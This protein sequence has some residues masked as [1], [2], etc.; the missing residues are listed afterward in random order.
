MSR[1]RRAQTDE[2][3]SIVFEQGEDDGTLSMQRT[4][5]MTQDILSYEAKGLL[6]TLLSFPDGWKT[7]FN[8][9]V[10]RFCGP[11]KLRR[12]I[13]E[14]ESSG[15]LWRRRTQL[16]DGTFSWVWRANKTARKQFPSVDEPSMEKP[17]MVNPQIYSNQ[18]SSN[19]LTESSNKKQ[20]I[21]QH[22][23]S[24]LASEDQDFAVEDVPAI[25]I[26]NSQPSQRQKKQPEFGQV[27][28]YQQMFEILCEVMM[29]DP[30][31][32]GGRIGQITKKLI[33]G[34]Y[35]PAQIKSWYG[36]G[37]WWYK[38]YWKGKKG[39]PPD[40]GD[41]EKTVKQAETGL[42]G[43]EA[44]QAFAVL[45]EKIREVGRM[46]DY[47]ELGPKTRAAIDKLG[48]WYNVCNYS[49]QMLPHAFRQ[50]YEG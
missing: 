43:N 31:L 38:H 3:G 49:E 50:A 2:E 10:T 25:A 20:V 22:S 35:E 19:K 39:S 11:D 33:K 41:I 47:T 12:I 5:F 29:M 36:Q 34:G 32:S 21:Q 27:S 28:T 24:A 9:L 37:G 1:Q 13:K 14:L 6:V 16:P 8:H 42:S 15:H 30:K 18:E 48:G 46:G 45:V 26:A 7:R 40:N 23:S 44:D 17:Y 4:L